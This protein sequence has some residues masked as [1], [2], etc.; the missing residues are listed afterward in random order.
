MN[1][2]EEDGESKLP[3]IRAVVYGKRW[4]YGAIQ[5]TRPVKLLSGKW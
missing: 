3:C 2:V 5:L 4:M 1:E